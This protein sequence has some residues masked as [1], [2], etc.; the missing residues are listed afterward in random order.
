MH[1]D[2]IINT[3][4]EY[5]MKHASKYGVVSLGVFGSIAKGTD[6]AESDIDICIESETP[7]PFHIVHIKMDLEELFAKK[8]DI[9]RMRKSMNPF[10]RQRI[11]SEAI[12]V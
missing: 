8:V 10:L 4:K 12:Y 3:L 5:K 11:E 9:V 7:N 1:R 6:K 2:E